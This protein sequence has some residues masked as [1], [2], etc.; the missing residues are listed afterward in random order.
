M[1][2]N[3]NVKNYDKVTNFIPLPRKTYSLEDNKMRL[4]SFQQVI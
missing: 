2:S 4:H 1:K 3:F